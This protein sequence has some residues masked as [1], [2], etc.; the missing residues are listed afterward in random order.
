MA[1]REMARVV[2]PGGIVAIATEWLLL[3]EYT[4]PE[5]FN[6]SEVFQ[7]LVDPFD[8]LEL[9][10]PVDFH[11]LTYEYL[12]DS[13]VYPSGIKRLRRHVILND[14][15]VQSTSIFLFFRVLG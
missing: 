1:V 10:S 9:I 4:H 11:T 13:I 3:Q 8:N 14:G 6:R 7:Y 15:R 2:R 5:F 12:V